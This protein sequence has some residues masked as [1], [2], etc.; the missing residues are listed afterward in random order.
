MDILAQLIG[1]Q[2]DTGDDQ[3]VTGL[4]ASYLLTGV[5]ITNIN[6]VD[7]RAETAVYTAPGGARHD[8]VAGGG[9]YDPVTSP[10]SAQQIGVLLPLDGKSMVP[11]HHAATLY[12]R[13]KT[14]WPAGTTGDLYI[15]GVAL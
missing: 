10:D 9:I 15:L 14:I 8:Q 4:P 2:L 6:A 5:V 12:A 11:V 7:L 3:A 1:M 13:A